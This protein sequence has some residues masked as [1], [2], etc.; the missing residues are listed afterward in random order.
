MSLQPLGARVRRTLRLGPTETLHMVRR[1]VDVAVTRRVSPVLTGVAARLAR[2][3][4]AG[5]AA[6]VTY[7]GVPDGH[8]LSLQVVLPAGTETRGT[9]ASLVFRH[10]RTEHRVPAVLRSAPD[11]GWYAEATTLL[12]RLPGGIPLGRGVWQLRIELT[13]T[14]GERQRLPVRR[15]LP[16]PVVGTGPTRAAPPC[17]DTG[18]RFR[19]LTTALGVCRLAVTPGR[20][21]AE[22]VRFTMGCGVAAIVGRFVGIPDTAGAIAE[23][24]RGDGTV[25]EEPVSASGDVFRIELPLAAL[26]PDA[27]GEQIWEAVIRLADGRRLQVGRFLHDLEHIRQTLR[28]YDRPVLLPGATAYRLRLQYT[29]AGRLNLI[30]SDI[31]T[32]EQG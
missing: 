31:N 21:A 7:L 12:G 5:E 1:Q 11:G 16:E 14:S 4:P 2:V 19:P 3:A 23:F 24:R 27:A 32:G 25:L 20:P 13:T 6:A 29:L 22:V 18:A 26:R 8:T 9:T 30:C 15:T 28:P 10:A 17:P